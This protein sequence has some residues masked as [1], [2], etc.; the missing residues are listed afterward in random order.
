MP[1]NVN[2]LVLFGAG[3]SFGSNEIEHVPPLGRDLFNALV[4]FDSDSW[5]AVL[6]QFAS[7]FRKDFEK[8]MRAFANAHPNDRRVDQ[9]Q[10]R[11]AAYFFRFTPRRESLYRK[12][13]CRIKQTGWRGALATLNYERLLELSLCTERL[14]PVVG[15]P[16]KQP[17]DIELCLPHGCC[18][19]FVNVRTETPTQGDGSPG[20]PRHGGASPPGA[21]LDV[22]RPTILKPGKGPDGKEV[23]TNLRAAQ[24]G[25]ITLGDQLHPDS[26]V[27]RVIDDLCDH[28]KELNE[29]DIPPVMC[30]IEPDKRTRA[31][32]SFITTQWKRFAKLVSEAEVIGVVGVQVRPR[33]RH[34][35]GPLSKANGKIIYCAGRD[36]DEQ[37]RRWAHKGGRKRDEDLSTYWREGFDAVCSAVGIMPIA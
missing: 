31:G 37:F 25:A 14:Q 33:D 32:D 4:E 3:A 19:L 18:H 21:I 8:G 22:P 7:E 6:P 30:Y 27:I 34:I 35:W 36:S 26:D 24:G 13:A 28:A 11:M 17:G 16:S 5:G 1:P 9:L 23:L 20:A 2:N 10:K 15:A 12:L 29:N